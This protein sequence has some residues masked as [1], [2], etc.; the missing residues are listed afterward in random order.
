MSAD[1]YEGPRC[2]ADVRDGAYQYPA[3]DTGDNVIDLTP[4]AGEYVELSWITVG[5]GLLLYGFFVDQTAAEA[6][7]DPTTASG[8][9]GVKVPTAPKRLESGSVQVTV[10][11][12]R[13]WL[14]LEASVST[15]LCTV[16]HAEAAKQPPGSGGVAN[17]PAA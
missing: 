8:S 5:V 7:F 3:L 14:R 11:R 4:W 1:N 15:G 12:T 2:G 10:P 17:P 6:G 16:H 13:L 9:P